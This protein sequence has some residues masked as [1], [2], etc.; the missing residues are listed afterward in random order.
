VYRLLWRPHFALRTLFIV[1]LA[2]ALVTNWYASR[3][4][5]MRHAAYLLEKHGASY[6]QGAAPHPW[7]DRLPFLDPPPRIVELSLGSGTDLASVVPA[8]SGLGTVRRVSIYGLT[9]RDMQLLSQI[10]SIR[11]VEAAFGLTTEQLRPLLS[12]PLEEFSVRGADVNIS[13]ADL[14]LLLSIPT[15][16]SIGMAHGESGVPSKLRDGHPNVSYFITDFPP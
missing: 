6:S 11:T 3:Y 1:T 2:V 15:L 9:T 16:K 8:L 12:L 4:R 13:P 7:Y 10:D 5:Q 14:E